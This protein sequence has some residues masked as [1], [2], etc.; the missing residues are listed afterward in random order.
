M[1][2]KVFCVAGL[3]FTLM[4]A[5]SCDNVSA[6]EIMSETTQIDDINTLQALPD[7]A[8]YYDYCYWAFQQGGKAQ[9]LP[10]YDAMLDRETTKL[11]PKEWIATALIDAGARIAQN[12][13]TQKAC[14]STFKKGTK[15]FD[16]QMKKS[17]AS[18]R[19]KAEYDKS[20]DSEIATVQEAIAKHWIEDQAARRVYIAS[21]TDD[22]TGADFWTYRLAVAR[23]SNADFN[24]TEYMKVLLKEYDWI[25]QKRFG[26]R[27]SMGAW[28]LVQHADDHVE[29]Q[30]LAL[31]RMEPY[32]NTDGVSK[33]DY[34][35]LWDRVAVNS[36]KKQRYGTQPN[37]E[38]TPEGKLTLQPLENPETVND[39]RAEMGMDS[40]EVGL[41]EMQRSVCG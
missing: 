18:H 32:L 17:L 23:T 11:S 1:F 3:S 27:V 26:E 9:A 21:K 5:Q 31:S 6:N 14:M 41:Q 15:K 37:W 33:T 10:D 20:N 22:K 28:L 36:G 13:D 12:A 4:T 39:R 25:D 35:Y 16:K 7:K 8:R 34:A 29:L 19:S 30:Q 24:S 38:C 2:R 40:V